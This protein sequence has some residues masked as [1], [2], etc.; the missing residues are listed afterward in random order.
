M[1]RGER[2]QQPDSFPDWRSD[3]ASVE[4]HPIGGHL[5]RAPVASEAAAA[6]AAAAEAAVAE[7][8]V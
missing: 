5:R 3:Q 8:C 2:E 6:E 1:F 7:A 4:C